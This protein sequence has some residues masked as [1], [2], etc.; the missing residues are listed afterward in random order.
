MVNPD[1]F[2]ITN[3]YV[4]QA[5]D[6]IIQVT[7]D[8][9][10]N[11]LQFLQLVEVH[12]LTVDYTFFPEPRQFA[13]NDLLIS[14]IQDQYDHQRSLHGL[15]PV[16]SGDNLASAVIAVK[17]AAAIANP[18]LIGW[19]WFYFHY[20]EVSLHIS[21][22]K[23]CQLVNLD[24]RTIRRYQNTIVD[25]LTKRLIRMEQS[26]RNSRH[27]QMLC[28]QLP[29][30]G[31]IS[32]LLERDQAIEQLRASKTKHFYITGAPGIGKTVFTEMF[33]QELISDNKLDQIVW[34]RSPENM[35]SIKLYLRERLLIENT[36]VTITEY[37]LIKQVAIVIDNSDGLHKELIELEY[38]LQEFSNAYVFLIS[39]TFF[40]LPNCFQ[41]NLSELS[42]SSA[43]T[44][45][46][47]PNEDYGEY[48]KNVDFN[49]VIWPS[50]GGNPLA[51]KLLSQNWS[52]F[53]IQSAALMTL[54]E[55]FSNIYSSLSPSEHLAWLILGLLNDS[56]T[57]LAG[58]SQIDSPHVSLDDFVTLSRLHIATTMQFDN[59]GIGLTL[60]AHQYIQHRYQSSQDLRNTFDA[61][62]IYKNW[63]SDISS[64][65][66]LILI[67]AVLVANWINI[68]RDYFLR[69]V[70]QFW[71]TG[72]LRGHYTKWHL[73]FSTYKE[74][75]TANN[76][77]IVIGH[78]ICERYLGQWSQAYSIFISVVQYAGRHGY[79]T[80]Q[81]E[82][83]LELAI[84]LRYQGDYQGT[85]ETL[86]HIDMLSVT[87]VSWEVQQRFLI[88][89]IELALESNNI[90][91]AKALLGNLPDNEPRKS[92]FQ[93]EIY[94]KESV[95][96]A[97]V[98]FAVSLSD[99]LFFNFGYSASITARVHILMGRIWEK[100]SDIATAI[101]HLSIAL[102]L[103]L[104]QD[105]DPFALAR[106]QSNLA[107]VLIRDN[108]LV[109]ARELLNSAKYIQRQI[110]DRV[111]LAV[112]IHNEH[113][114]DRKIV[115]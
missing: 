102:S 64:N 65:I 5:L 1:T 10:I 109:E 72:L 66:D 93:I 22:Q 32:N 25:Q 34:F 47:D 44:L 77:D 28:L 51:I 71:K 42:I 11:P 3:E 43:K 75:L 38:F 45:L 50:I 33:L 4:R 6:Q 2:L 14:I 98:D 95:S 9:N 85:I 96:S 35:E 88:E 16:K 27:K 61:F 67:E 94:A 91:E 87:S 90:S 79:F 18:D 99:K 112:T 20:V 12:M 48:F 23:F 36:N 58:L 26:A 57:T 37:V 15:P 73:I 114:I 49:R 81:A 53:D 62:M 92:V 59:V 107:G 63:N 55:I 113:V 108:K 105:N 41:L 78:G 104:E 54:D 82:A 80:R 76:L 8:K 60:S 31:N 56:S 39:R 68:D 46:V 70:H 19:A 7:A 86:N 52:T 24:D 30:Q 13:L 97:K 69:A 106:T 89:R 40:P 110:Q 74:E 17:E 83:L 100:N 101:K 115:N 21:Q 103:L 111:G 29:H 84:L